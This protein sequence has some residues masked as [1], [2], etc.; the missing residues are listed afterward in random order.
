MQLI[1]NEMKQLPVLPLSL[2]LPAHEA[3][4]RRCRAFLRQPDV[5]EATD[6]W[7]GALRMSRRSFSR[8]F[9]QETGMTFVA[10]R[11][12]VCLLHALPR[13]GAGKAVTA[14]AIELGYETPAAFTLMFRRAFDS[15]PLAYLGGRSGRVS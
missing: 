14:V 8:F 11:Q 6:E 7:A 10:W 15:P 12:Q 9:R 4:A 3:L 13:M 1:G 2:Q 5:H